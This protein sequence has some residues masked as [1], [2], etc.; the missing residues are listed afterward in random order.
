[1]IN[2][3]G[4][5]GVL[6]SLRMKVKQAMKG[7]PADDADMKGLEVFLENGAML[8]DMV[9]VDGGGYSVITNINF[10]TVLLQI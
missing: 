1:M 7:K 4:P 5:I 3:K 9:M 8:E 10:C 6:G 2:V